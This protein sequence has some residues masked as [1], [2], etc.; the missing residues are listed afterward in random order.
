MYSEIEI[1]VKEIYN[2]VNPIPTLYVPEN[3]FTTYVFLNLWSI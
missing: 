1:N 3:H 2:L